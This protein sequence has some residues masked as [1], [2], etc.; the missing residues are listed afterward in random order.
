[1][2]DGY[3]DF[4]RLASGALPLRVS[5][6]LAAHAWRELES[7]LRQTLAGRWRL[8]PTQQRTISQKSKQPVGWVTPEARVRE[9]II[10]T[11]KVPEKG[12]GS[13][14]PNYDFGL[15]YNA[16]ETAYRG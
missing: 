5:I 8:R 11:S 13:D 3:V 6:P 7:I 14:F 15:T 4:C 10:D 9:P 1:M 12:K 2:A 16:L